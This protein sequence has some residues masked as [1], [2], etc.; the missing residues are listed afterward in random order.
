MQRR[1]RALGPQPSDETT[2]T[3]ERDRATEPRRDAVRRGG[4]GHRQ[5]EGARRPRRRARH[6]RRPTSGAD[7]RDRR[8][9][10]HREGGGRAARPRPRASSSAARGDEPTTSRERCARRSTS[11]TAPRSAR[12]TRSRSASSP[13]F[14]IEAGLA[15]AHRGAR[16]DRR[17]SSRSRSG[18]AG[19]VDEL[20]DDPEL[21]PI[22]LLV[23]LAARRHARAPAPASPEFLD[24][25]WDLVDRIG[26]RPTAA[27]RS[28][29]DAWLAELDAVVRDARASAP[30]PTTSCS[31]GSASSTACA[32]PAAATP[33]TTSSAS[34]CCSPTK[35]SFKV[36]HV[37]AAR[38]NWRRRRTTV[39]ARDRARS[40]SS[41]RRSRDRRHRRR[42]PPRRRR[43][44]ARV[45]GRSTPPSAARAGELEFHDLLVL[46]RA[47]LRDPRA[48]A[49][50][51]ARRLRDALPAPAARRVPGHRPD[52]GRARGA[53]R[54][55]GDPDARDATGGTSSRSSPGRL[56]VVGDPKQ[57]IYRFRRADI[58]DVPRAR[59]TAFGDR[60]ASRSRATS[61]PSRRCIDWVNHVFARAHRSRARVAAR[62]RRAR[63]ACAARR[64]RARRSML[65]GV[66]PHDDE[67]D[68]DE[69]R[70]RE[71]ADVAAA[72]A[73]RDRRR[74][75]RCDDRRRR[76]SGA[77][78]RLGDICILLPARTSLGYLEDALDAAGIPYRAETSS[79]VYGTRE[80]RDLLMVLR[81]VDDPT[82]ELALVSALRS[83]LF[84]CGDDDLFTFQVEHGGRW[85]SPAPPPETLPGRPSGRRRRCACLARAGTTHRT[86]VGAERAARPHR[87]RAARARGRRSPT[88]GS[89]TVARRVRF[90]VDQARAFARR[91][92]RQRCATTSRG[93]TL[94]G[95]PRARGSSRP[96]CPRP[97]TTRCA[98]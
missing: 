60:A 83:P 67:A 26:D 46:A 10:V 77:P 95:Q 59:A 47:L 70:E 9:H 92:R 73:H 81:A 25:N 6:R 14:P 1:A 85:D 39:R 87:A 41:A 79:L 5:D 15:A 37:R 23:L 94:P 64:R 21:E 89:A 34:S 8:D 78:A 75:G 20:L 96:C 19:S 51:C 38:S 12:C 43:S 66:E 53:A 93:P 13:T 33:S 57:S 7:A 18:G 56:F 54:V 11:S 80:V 17:R 68:A 65:L 24:D 97:T 52:P 30:T 45:H 72:V 58:A 98:S 40:A 61:A 49:R 44:L 31:A 2:A 48:R 62:V 29:L 36:R 86:W 42:A 74:R 88:A 90:V 69:L 16:R 50:T 82:D 91:G 22:V 76:A 28:T 27:R 3:R 35:P 55:A 63:A 32:R 84:G 4:R 71:A